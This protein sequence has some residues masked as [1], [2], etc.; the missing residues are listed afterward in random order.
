[1]HA[2][3]FLAPAEELSV[4]GFR[5]VME[6]DAV[7]SF[8]MS[9][10]AFPALAKSKDGR[11]VNISAT[12]HYGATWYQVPLEHMCS[13]VAY[14]SNS[15]SAIE[16]ARARSSIQRSPGRNARNRAVQ[17]HASAAKAAIDSMTRTLA[18]EWGRY[19]IRVNGVAPGPIRGTAG[20]S[21]LAPGASEEALAAEMATTI[22]VGRMGEREDIALACVYLS[23]SAGSFM[24]GTTC[25]AHKHKYAFCLWRLQRAGMR[26]SMGPSGI[27]VQLMCVLVTIEDAVP[28]CRPVQGT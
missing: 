16:H 5:T 6:I 2:G 14:S 21:K 27:C 19:G 25:P 4:N 12:L 28:H 8:N 3:N 26:V 22:P 13:S 9:R 1:V 23:S 11:I 20:M 10:A 24:S 15:C 7:G 17:V 18:L